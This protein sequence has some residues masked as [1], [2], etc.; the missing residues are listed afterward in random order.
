MCEYE[1]HDIGGQQALACEQRTC[2]AVKAVVS[3]GT[4]EPSTI[5]V[6]DTALT[7]QFFTL[8]IET[9]GLI[10]IDASATEAWLRVGTDEVEAD[11]DTASVQGGT[12]TLI[13]PYSWAEGLA[14]GQYLIGVSVTAGNATTGTFVTAITIE[15]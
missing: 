7:D 3:S 6:A 5:T 11:I 1:P 4:I 10:D 2:V 13:I 12:I 9:E 14:A 8:T 15:P